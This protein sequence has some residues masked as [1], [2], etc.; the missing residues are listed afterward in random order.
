[1]KPSERIEGLEIGADDYLPKPFEP[2]ELILR[3]KNILNK[4]KKISQKRVIE[5][6]KIKIDLNKLIILKNNKEFKINN[7][8]KIILE[9]MINNP[10]KIFSR[11]NIG[12]LINLDKERSIDVIITR[13]RKKLRMIQ[14]IPNFYKQ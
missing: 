14:K 11:E 7:T 5:F 4:T 2:K 8:E 1:M 6:D 10:G 13:L 12:T 3:I 9:R